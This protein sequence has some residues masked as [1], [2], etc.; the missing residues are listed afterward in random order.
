M[1][2][3]SEIVIVRQ[4]VAGCVPDLLKQSGR[5]ANSVPFDKKVVVGEGPKAR[6]AVQSLNQCCAFEQ[7]IG[8]PG[9]TEGRVDVGEIP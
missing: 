2:M 9:T 3:E 8:Y 6:I 1:E 7:D 5:L 4:G